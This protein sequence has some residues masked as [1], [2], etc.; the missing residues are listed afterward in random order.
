MKEKDAQKQR[1]I[2]MPPG[3]DSGVKARFKK[4]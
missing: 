1:K 2:E 3:Q 4:A